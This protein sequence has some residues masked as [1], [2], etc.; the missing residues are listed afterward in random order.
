MK[1]NELL[2]II[3]NKTERYVNQ[4][5]L[6]E[7][8]GITR[9][10][11]SNRIKNESQVTVSELKR[12]EDFFNITLFN[13]ADGDDGEVVYIDYYTDIF[14]SCGNGNILFSDEKVRIPVPTTLINGFT[15]QKTYSM[16]NASGN[17]MTPT[18]CDGDRLIVEHWNGEQIQDNRIY[19][20][21]FNQEFFIKRLSK[22]LDEII[23]K[24]DNPEYRV[25]TIN[26]NT[27]NELTLIGKIIGI[28]KTL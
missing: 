15:N 22:N 8:L 10:T 6:A 4:S 21:C 24:S 16:I 17:S 14:A 23:I 27:I 12:I 3:S 7:A 19:V 20:F 13:N 11:V 26:G 2:K 5:L 9:Q 28:I 25:R 1:L 18:I